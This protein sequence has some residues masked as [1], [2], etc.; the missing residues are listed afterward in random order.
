MT[1][2]LALCL[3]MTSCSTTIYGPDGKPKMRTFAD[4]SNV[5]YKDKEC[6]FHADTLNHSAPTRATGSVIGT[7][8]TGAAAL[9]IGGVR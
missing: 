8:M 4:A 2:L 5:S 7:T 6:E 3:L 9:G 1:R